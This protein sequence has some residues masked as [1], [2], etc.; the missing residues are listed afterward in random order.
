MELKDMAIEGC[1]VWDRLQ[2]EGSKAF[3]AFQLYRDMGP[4]RTVSEVVKRLWEEKVVEEHEQAQRL[5]IMCGDPPPTPLTPESIVQQMSGNPPFTNSATNWCRE[6]KWTER[7]KAWEDHLD[8]Q[9]QEVT[10]DEVREMQKRHL[11]IAG[12]IQNKAVRRLNQMDDSEL[13]PKN[14]LDYI[15]S[16]V[17]L[18]RLTREQVTDSTSVTVHNESSLG[19]R[20]TL[21]GRI[22]QIQK[23]RQMS[24]ETLQ[25]LEEEVIAEDES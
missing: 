22:L 23:Q 15:E 4:T 2:N 16:G 17:K 19:A 9:R 14:V 1:Q 7:V 25:R 11:S 24:E 20:E 8:K 18:E 6:Y 3:H 21:K 12:V 10:V 5:S 13:T